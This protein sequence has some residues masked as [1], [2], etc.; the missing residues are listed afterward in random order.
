MCRGLE[1]TDL[2]LLVKKNN[3]IDGLPVTGFLHPAHVFANREV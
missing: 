1:F 3:N 2:L